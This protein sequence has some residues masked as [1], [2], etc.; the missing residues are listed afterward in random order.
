MRRHLSPRDLRHGAERNRT[1]ATTI[2]TLGE[3]NG[4]HAQGIHSHAE[5]HE[6]SGGIGGHFAANT[7][8]RTLGAGVA[9]NHADCVDETSKDIVAVDL[10]T[11][12]V[13]DSAQLPKMLDLIADEVGQVSADR[14]YDSATCYEAI[15]ARGAVPAIPPRRNAKFSNAKDP[16]AFR[17]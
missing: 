13:H 10:T 11:S 4:A 8:G 17:A 7:Y 15:L 6:S 2:L 16:P 12:S 14:A 1:E 3:T 5:M 9:D